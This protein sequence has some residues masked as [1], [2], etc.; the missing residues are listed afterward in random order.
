MLLTTW[1][2]TRVSLIVSLLLAAGM[3]QRAAGATA[4][5]NP[6][7][8]N[9]LYESATGA[10]SNGAGPTLYAGKTGANNAYLLRRAVLAFD[11]SSFPAGST[12]TDASLALQVTRTNGALAEPF[13]LNPLTASWGEGA[14]NA[15]SPGGGGGVAGTG[16]ATWIHRFYNTSAWTMPG[17]DYSPTVSASQQLAG[18]GSYVFSSPQTAADVQGWLDNPSVNFGWVLR[19]DESL[20]QG[21]LGAKEFASSEHATLGFRPML[22]VNYIVPEP[23]ALALIAVG[24][25]GLLR[26]RRAD[27]RH[28]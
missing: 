10:L 17:G 21:T 7:K 9:T 25:V 1:P 16:D 23:A 28:C 11:F 24:A 5:L 3:H 22:T 4:Q 12:V 26:R 2:I 8:D 14:S 18:V 20:A 13:T 6:D 15:G 27:D 19:G